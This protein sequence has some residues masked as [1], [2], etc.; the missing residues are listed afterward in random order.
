[1]SGRSPQDL[2]E[3]YRS[4]LQGDDHAR[5]PSEAPPAWQFGDSPEMAEELGALVIAGTKRATAG[6]VWEYEAEGAALPQPGA[7]EIVLDGR[8]EP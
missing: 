2:W 8:G 5:L 3:E 7:Y 1:M 6:L 4:T